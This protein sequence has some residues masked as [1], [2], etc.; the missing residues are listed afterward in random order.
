MK[1]LNVAIA[2]LLAAFALQTP[3]SA[4]Q[5][6][7]GPVSEKISWAAP[8]VRTAAD[9]DGAAIQLVDEDFSGL[10]AG[11][12][13]APDN[14]LLEDNMGWVNSGLRPYHESCTKPWG[15]MGLTSA[16]GTIAVT[17]GFL[18]TP[19][20]DY[21]GKMRM[22]CRV[23]LPKGTVV[24]DW[25]GNVVEQVPLDII[26]LR[27][28]VF[29]DFKRV[30]YNLT[31][32]W[33]EITFEADNGWFSDTM[34][35]F[36]TAYDMTFLVDDVKIEHVITSIEYPHATS[37]INVS[38]DS[39]IANW[40][41]TGTAEEY[42]LSVY[43][44]SENPVTDVEEGDFETISS[45]DGK[46][47][48]ETNPGY[49]EGWD[50]SVTENGEE[51][52]IFT[53]EGMYNSG[54]QSVCLD[55]N[56][57][58]IQGRAADYPI[59]AAHFWINVD[60][61]QMPADEQSHSTLTIQ[62]NNGTQWF[63]LFYLSV[64]AARQMKEGVMVDCAEY[65]G[66]VD[67][68]MQMRIL[69]NKDEAD[70]C[71]V[72]IDDFGFSAPGELLKNYVFEDKV[73][74][75]DS[76]SFLVTVPDANAEY[77]YYLKARNSMFTS[78]MSNEIEVFDVHEPVALPAT[79]ITDDSYVANWQ[80]GPKSDFFT[81]NQYLRY[82]AEE[83]IPEYVV[84]EE[85]F[86]KV[87]STGTPEAPETGELVEEF[88]DLDQYTDIPGWKA[89]SY[90]IASGMLGGTDASYPYRIGSILLPTMDLS[91]ND[92]VCNVTI[93]AYGQEGDWLII[94]GNSQ[95]T[96]GAMEFVET[97]MKEMTFTL[98]GC[99]K[100]EEFEIYTQNYGSFLIDYIKI[101]QPLKAG[102]DVAILTKKQVTDN[103]GDRAMAFAD[104]PF[105]EGMDICYNIYAHRL[106]HGS[107]DEIWRSHASNMMVVDN[108]ATG[109]CQ[110]HEALPSC[111]E[112]RDGGMAVTMKA[113]GTV[114]IY[115]FSGCLVKSVRLEAGENQINMGSGAY[116]VSVPGIGRAKVLIR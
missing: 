93:R 49:P 6:R 64:E 23:R 14:T 26:L 111:I 57:D 105:R 96:V 72:A 15:G 34:I 39:F 88:V 56:G 58:Y 29:Q 55:A 81:V 85:D 43:T 11:T 10:T 47:I 53:E 7:K 99:S 50:I 86:S 109:I 36:F 46:M 51:R 65:L 76:C 68:V 103:A 13:D 97:G 110:A 104:V 20:G 17:N 2:S 89:G 4:Q 3:C 28:S 101:T 24:T 114:K 83:D 73:I 69:M 107:E 70:Q 115:D 108:N 59:K 27:R 100:D 62:V 37:A 33:Q 22:T 54:K 35:Q 9:V 18:N 63:D 82:T 74:A 40:E 116:I 44:K 67:K 16:G 32:E 106:Y 45:K 84:L 48:D 38:D 42:L 80:C 12:E 31:E 61:S 78:D 98:E 75:K 90:N 66:M 21:S 112:V 71:L 94:G 95:V 79:D 102:E 5:L 41:P 60:D 113:E 77:F 8:C 25:Y 1:K 19:T 52:H 91:H 87:V 30:T 92:G